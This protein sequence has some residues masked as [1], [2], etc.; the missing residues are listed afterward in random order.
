VRLSRALNIEDLRQITRRRLPRIVYEYLEGGSE[1]EVT[2]AANREVFEAIKFA[3]RQLLRAEIDRLLALLGCAS[4]D[5]LGP[6]Y[7]RS[8]QREPAVVRALPL[9]RLRSA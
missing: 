7:L 5:D 4:I 1:D 8:A 6:Q 9:A 2:L 3:P